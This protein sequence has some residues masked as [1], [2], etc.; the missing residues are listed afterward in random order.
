MLCFS[1]QP[2]GSSQG[3]DGAPSELG[4]P[5]SGADAVP[6]SEA[7]ESAPQLVIW[8]TD[9]SVQTYKTKFRKFL[10]HF[11]VSEIDPDEKFDEFNAN[12]PLYVQIMEQVNDLE[13]PY[14]NV[15]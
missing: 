4:V 13:E 3:G 10:E 8:G 7:S 15:S 9:V 14:M 1:S 6:P 12:E 5:N 2:A 11:I